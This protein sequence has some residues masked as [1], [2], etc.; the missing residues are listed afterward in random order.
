MTHDMMHFNYL[1]L[2]L[3]QN[4]F[5]FNQIKN[6]LKCLILLHLD[7]LLIFRIFEITFTLSSLSR[8]SF[9]LIERQNETEV[10]KGKKYTSKRSTYI[11]RTNKRKS[12]WYWYAANAREQRRE[13]RDEG[14][15]KATGGGWRLV[16]AHKVD[17]P[18]A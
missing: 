2:I 14:E 15:G 4:F 8:E 18:H 6:F 11:G 12:V 5:F 10:T 17:Q 1:N 13:G 9:S 7:F 3:F 16:V